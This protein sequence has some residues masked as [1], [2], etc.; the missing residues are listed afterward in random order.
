VR[1]LESRRRRGEQ[2]VVLLLVALLLLPFLA[3]AAVLVDVGIADLARERMQIAAD[4]GALEGAR[5]WRAPDDAS[6]CADPPAPPA[7]GC[8]PA[9]A[10][11]A[12]DAVRRERA[13]A[14]AGA[15]FAPAAPGAPRAGPIRVPEVTPIGEERGLTDPTALAE[16]GSAPGLR[17][18]APGPL[19]ANPED[20][21]E[22]DLVAGRFLGRGG[23]PVPSCPD[24]A[25]AEPFGENC[26]YERSDFVARGVDPGVGGRDLLVRL[27]LTGEAAV[28]GVAR[29][30]P[31]VPALFGRL[32]GVAGDPAAPPLRQRGVA[33]RATAIASARPALVAGAWVPD[34]G[35]IG[36]G[37]VG[38]AV[39]PPDAPPGFW[40]SLDPETPVSLGVD[41]DGALRGPGEQVVG[42]VI[43]PG[44]GWLAVGQAVRSV[45]A[46]PVRLDPEGLVALYRADPQGTARIVAFGRARL[47]VDPSDPERRLLVKRRAA[48]VAGNAAVASPAHAPVLAGLPPAV[49]EDV[50]RERS[51]PGACDGAGGLEPVCAAGIAR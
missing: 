42:Q 38:L 29:P 11:A 17:L 6:W 13:S 2:G 10:F 36:A 25:V 34:S 22:G 21:P 28:S 33:V 39:A 1:D 23:P 40:R 35:V 41:P 31:T 20:R 49:V 37:N 26:R 30:E 8:E 50:F 9:A 47:V 4:A 24:P 32:V 46:A 18:S 14:A 7:P 19:A 48:V 15:V 45:A 12:W 43:A 44:A 3:L 51:L 5:G 27:R 16:L